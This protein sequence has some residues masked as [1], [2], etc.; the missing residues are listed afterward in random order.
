MPIDCP[1]CGSSI[2]APVNYRDAGI[3]REL[4]IIWNVVPWY[5]GDGVRIRAAKRQD[6]SAGTA[7]LKRL[8]TLLPSVR[9][10]V[11]VDKKAQQASSLVSRLRPD[12]RVFDSPHRSPLFINNAPGN[13]E[14]ILTVL[15][16][17]AAYLGVSHS[18]G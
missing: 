5:L 13:R 14:H 18:A 1:K 4:T 12:V 6:V 2:E 10:I 11:L 9:A 17:V 8:L 7:S 15:R 3:P 16:E